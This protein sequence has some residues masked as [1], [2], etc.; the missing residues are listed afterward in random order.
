MPHFSQFQNQIGKIGHFK[1]LEHEKLRN[2]PSHDKILFHMLFGAFHDT[3]C[4]SLVKT[5]DA[6]TV[7]VVPV[8]MLYRKRD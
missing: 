7:Q 8:L 4:I 6:C 3:S 5:Y 1:K 2:L